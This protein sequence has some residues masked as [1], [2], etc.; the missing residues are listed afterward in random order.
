MKNQFC[1][2]SLVSC[3]AF[4]VLA[5]SPARSL[6]Q[7]APAKVSSVGVEQDPYLWLEEIEGQRALEFVKEQNLKTVAALKGDPLF[8]PTADNIK[9]ILASKDKLSYVNFYGT[10][11]Y[12]FWQDDTHPRGLWRRSGLNDYLST[13]GKPQWE[14]VLDID[15]LSKSE[16]ES[17]VW[18]GATCLQ[19][20]YTRCVIELS[21]GGKDAKVI[22]EF[23]TASKSFITQSPFQLDESKSD[24]NWI[25][26]NHLL[27][28][29]DFGEDSVTSSGYPRTTQIWRRDE[30][31]RHAPVIFSGDKSD[32]GIWANHYT[33]G[34]ISTTIITRGLTFFTSQYFRVNPDLSTT[35]LDLP[36]DT[37]VRGY[38][39]GDLIVSPRTDWAIDGRIFKTGS[40]V[41]FNMNT[42]RPTD[43]LLEPNASTSIN[44]LTVT[45]NSIV[46]GLLEN[47]ASRIVVFE[48]S[49]AGW[50]K[51]NINLPGVGSV[52]EITTSSQHDDFFFDFSSFLKPTSLF[53]AKKT[54]RRYALENT[55]SLPAYF[56][57][58]DLIAEQQWAISKDGTRIPYFIIHR[59]NFE[60][61]GKNPTLLMGYGG[62]EVSLTPYYSGSIGQEWLSKGGLYVVANI[63]GGGEF[64]P[65]WHQAALKENRQRAFDDFIAVAEDLIQRGV[66]SPKHLGI[67]GGSNGGLLVGAV[68][69]QRPELFNAVI[70]Q[71][72]LLD[73]LRFHKLL[74]GAS[75][76]GEYG[77]PDESG[78]AADAIRGYSPYQNVK[79]GVRYPKIFLRTSTRDDRVHP[80]HARKM[81][82][83]MI[84]QGHDVLLFENTEGGHAGAADLNQQADVRAMEWIFLRQQ[85]N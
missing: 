32:V 83:R 85:L 61:N 4:F 21:R 36:E 57:A 63:R 48:K 73:M 30:P 76:M 54:G 11:V 70:C 78:P 20:E 60:L 80:G 35:R 12:N 38:F 67:Q 77:N 26:I 1:L 13:Q 19:P 39:K 34:D 8:R 15:A 5:C 43:L 28:S 27:L 56:N 29:A 66:T 64:G 33:H 72:P 69:V 7:S 46:I 10:T 31:P 2:P 24:V 9:S 65:A 53:F 71:V 17:W 42:N 62:F 44:D 59:R 37:E 51:N 3:L 23:D 41:I 68:M 45:K 14:I 55:A 40:V 84:E 25:D 50:T 74:A 6:I 47:I 82:A 79:A 49:A 81:A 22:R 52:N 18:K 75:W 16:S 58:Q